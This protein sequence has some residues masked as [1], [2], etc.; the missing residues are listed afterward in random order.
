V[1]VPQQR[2]DLERNEAERLVERSGARV[3][4]TRVRRGK[5]LRLQ[6]LDAVLRA[7]RLGRT[8]ERATDPFAVPVGQDAHHVD[9]G[10]PRSVAT[11]REE[12]CATLVRERRQAGDVVDVRARRLLDPE[13]VGER[14]EHGRCE[15]RA[16]GRALE[17]D[18]GH[19][20]PVT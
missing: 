12:A 20:R 17:L 1:L 10:R 18:D 2:K 14:L 7:P 3:V 5:R 6:Q 13:P 4:L 11:E 16:L 9:L 15:A 8:Y 19:A